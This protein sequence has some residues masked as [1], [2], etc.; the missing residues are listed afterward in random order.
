[1]QDTLSSVLLLF[2]LR[3]DN[4]NSSTCFQWV[5]LVSWKQLSNQKCY[6][7]CPK[8]ELTYDIGPHRH[9]C[10]VPAQSEHDWLYLDRLF[11]L[12]YDYRALYWRQLKHSGT[13]MMFW[14][15]PVKRYDKHYAFCV[16]IG[17]MSLRQFHINLYKA[18]ISFRPMC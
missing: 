7:Y 14:R 13:S 17:T 15:W 2:R 4:S 16:N 8:I 11:L 5:K 9:G 10:H 18:E 6:T 3:H 1:L 12:R